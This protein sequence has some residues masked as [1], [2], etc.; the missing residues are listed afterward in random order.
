MNNTKTEFD[1][2]SAWSLSLLSLSGAYELPEA[3]INVIHDL[4]KT[5]EEL[6]SVV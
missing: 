3:V 5:V 4:N 1:S 6:V 2:I